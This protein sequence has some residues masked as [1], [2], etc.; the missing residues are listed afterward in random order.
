[1]LVAAII[2]GNFPVF[3]SH[4]LADSP[5]G[6]DSDVFS[7]LGLDTNKAPKGYDS[8]STDNPYGK[9]VI[10]IAPVYE[11]FTVGLNEP[12][13]YVSAFE[14]QTSEIHTDEKKTASYH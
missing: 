9:D 11:L 12:L 8:L 3:R 14:I 6:S 2:L 10:E 13:N 5:S 4:V 1:M 7:A